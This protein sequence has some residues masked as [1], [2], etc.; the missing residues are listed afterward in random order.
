MF[1]LEH[2][3]NAISP[4]DGRYSSKLDKKIKQINSERGL[5]KQRVYIEVSWFIFL[6]KINSIKSKYTI[7]NSEKKYLLDI[8]EKFNVDDARLIKSIEDNEKTS[9]SGNNRAISMG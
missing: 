1:E 6:F 5:I 2:S 3:I 8:V 7:N 9:T 4:L